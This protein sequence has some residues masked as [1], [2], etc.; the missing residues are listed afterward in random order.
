MSEL[1][2]LEQSATTP[3]GKWTT[4]YYRQF[5]FRAGYSTRGLT[6]SINPAL[7]FISLGQPYSQNLT[8]A[9]SIYWLDAGTSWTAS[10]TQLDLKTGRQWMSQGPLTEGTIDRPMMVVFVYDPLPNNSSVNT[11]Q[12]LQ[13][14]GL[15][16]IA[17]LGAVAGLVFKKR[18][19]SRQRQ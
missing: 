3:G 12:A 8:V 5:A 7:N 9:S 18:R 14:S 10:N 1:P 4:T 17:T 15:A 2:S 6:D 19:R 13:Y 16:A 11:L